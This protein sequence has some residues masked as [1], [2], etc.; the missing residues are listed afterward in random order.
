MQITARCNICS[1]PI[2]GGNGGFCSALKLLHRLLCWRFTFP[3]SRYQ[4][5]PVAQ[6]TNEVFRRMS[7]GRRWAKRSI[8]AQSLSGEGFVRSPEREETKT[9]SE[10]A[11]IFPLSGL[12]ITLLVGNTRHSVYIQR[13]TDVKWSHICPRVSWWWQW[14]RQE[15]CGRTGTFIV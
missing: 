8:F 3:V 11:G 1:A 10:S 2:Q 13:H 12:S 15:G 9:I 7:D 6:N 5:S 4:S 14:R